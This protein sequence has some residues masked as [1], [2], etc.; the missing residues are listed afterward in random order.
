MKGNSPEGDRLFEQ[1][2][3]KFAEAIRI[4]PDMHDAFSNWGNGLVIQ[5]KLK[6]NTPEADRL[7]KEA[8]AK[9][10]QVETLKHGFGAY[11]QSCLHRCFE[12]TGI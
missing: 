11:I 4:K 6:G 5:A 8:N 1:A 9:L 12:I 7:F 2:G 3:Q 10:K